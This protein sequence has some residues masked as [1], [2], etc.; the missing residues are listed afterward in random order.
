MI[1]DE[2]VGDGQVGFRCSRGCLGQIFAMTISREIVRIESKVVHGPLRSQDRV[3][4]KG[5]R[6]VLRV[7][8]A[9]NKLLDEI[10]VL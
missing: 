2:L 3:D 10:N 4:R 5:L 8:S 6:K 7:Y 9:N 1:T